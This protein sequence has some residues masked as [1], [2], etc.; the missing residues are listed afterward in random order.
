MSINLK[1]VNQAI[2]E[3]FTGPRANPLYAITL[4]D[5]P[6][7]GRFSGY[8]GSNTYQVFEQAMKKREFDQRSNSRIYLAWNNQLHIPLSYAANA[9]N[10]FKGPPAEDFS[11]VIEGKYSYPAVLHISSDTEPQRNDTLRGERRFSELRGDFVFFPPGST[12]FIDGLTLLHPNFPQ[13][14]VDDY[15]GE[16]RIYAYFTSSDVEIADEELKRM[17]QSVKIFCR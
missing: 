9:Y 8:H 15:Y 14:L 3:A 2:H 7:R 1:L 16:R 17:I 13:G 12:V 4:F 6:A 11:H 10:P 5:G